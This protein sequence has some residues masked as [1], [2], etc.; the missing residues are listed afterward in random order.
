MY[1]AYKAEFTLGIIGAILGINTFMFVFI[2][3]TGSEFWDSSRIGFGVSAAVGMLMSMA[4]F[5]LGFISIT[6]LNINNK[7]GGTLLVVSGV[8]SFLS[9]VFGGL[10]MSAGDNYGFSMSYLPMLLL[11]GVPET[12]LMLTGGIMALARKRQIPQTPPF[13]AKPPYPPNPYYAAY[14]PPYPPSPSGAPYAP[15]PPYAPYPPPAQPPYPQAPA[16]PPFMQTPPVQNSEQTKQDQ[17][18]KE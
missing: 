12:A 10:A 2:G 4:A 7:G 8:L 17:L 18:P 13:A 11:N 5:I 14:P 1:K 15:H 6:K 3:L 9:I 16:Q